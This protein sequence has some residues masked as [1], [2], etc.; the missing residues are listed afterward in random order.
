M[1]EERIKIMEMFEEAEPLTPTDETKRLNKIH[2]L[3]LDMEWDLM[4]GYR[5][6]NPGYVDRGRMITFCRKIMRI[7][8]ADREDI[9]ETERKDSETKNNEEG[10]K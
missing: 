4:E 8:E 1:S 5:G 7:L 2:H 3:V 9:L 10:L 6:W